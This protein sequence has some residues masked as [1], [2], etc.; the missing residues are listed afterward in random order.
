MPNPI[1]QK[2]FTIPSPCPTALIPPIWSLDR[3][4]KLHGC[5]FTGTVNT[6]AFTGPI[7]TGTFFVSPDS[8][9][10]GT[11]PLVTGALD[12]TMRTGATTAGDA[13]TLAGTV[14]PGSATVTVAPKNPAL[15]LTGGT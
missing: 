5:H 14:N 3:A 2:Y 10:T 9:I 7:T 12:G 15:T 13:I 4:N 8:V 6:G 11:V 1:N